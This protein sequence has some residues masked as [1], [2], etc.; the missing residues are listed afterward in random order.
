MDG[1]NGLAYK[2]K[3]RNKR[4]TRMRLTRRRKKIRGREKKIKEQEKEKK[5]LG[6]GDES[7]G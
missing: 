5:N 7:M 3:G 2:S 4:S 1:R 6:S